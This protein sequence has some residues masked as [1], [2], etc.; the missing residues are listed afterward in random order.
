MNLVR[1]VYKTYSLITIQIV[2][3]L[4]RDFIAWS[5]SQREHFRKP[6]SYG[7]DQDIAS[8]RTEFTDVII[9]DNTNKNMGIK[10]NVL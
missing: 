1:I 5:L 4:I 3:R 10:N 8:V 7:L 6:N 9:T 2:I